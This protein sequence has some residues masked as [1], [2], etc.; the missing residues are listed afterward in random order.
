LPLAS[1]GFKLNLSL[2]FLFL[3]VGAA[4]A[5]LILYG[6][7]RMQDN[8]T[9]RSHEA[10]EELGEV[11][12]EGVVAGQASYGAVAID[13]ASE[14]GHRAGNYMA[15]FQ[16]AGS[17]AQAD[18]SQLIRAPNGALFNPDPNR[19]SDVLIP[20]YVSITPEVM[21]DFQYSAALDSLYPALLQSVPGSVKNA[22]FNPIAIYFVSSN[23]V[24]RSYPTR[25]L[26]PITRRDVRL[27]DLLSRL[28]PANNPER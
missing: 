14:M 8:A 2:L 18:F 24:I 1:L 28:G 23:G 25:S 9:T 19:I 13:G 21:D 22:D 4:T 10:L 16:Q 12:V 6:L 17:Q 20:A 15:S 11:A 3:M 26:N 27:P 7:N 5:A